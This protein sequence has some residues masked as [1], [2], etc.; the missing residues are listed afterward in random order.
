MG[1]R[2]HV[3]LALMAGSRKRNLSDQPLKQ[4]RAQP[5]SRKKITCKKFISCFLARM[6][7]L[8]VRPTVRARLGA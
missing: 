2:G 7:G 8:M 3:A 6:L 5:T 4:S 1:F